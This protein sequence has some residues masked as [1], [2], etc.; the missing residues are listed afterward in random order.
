[1]IQNNKYKLKKEI[2]KNKEVGKKIIK[3]MIIFI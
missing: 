3:S 2:S 1:M